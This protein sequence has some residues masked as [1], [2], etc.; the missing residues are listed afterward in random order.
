MPWMGCL[1]K[2]LNFAPT[3][4]R[5]PYENV[6]CGV[7]EAI[8]R[9][10]IPARDAETLRQ[11]VAVTLRKSQLPQRNITAEE[12]RAIKDLRADTDILVL[13]AD[14]GNATVVLDV[15]EYDRKVK[16]LLEDSST[17]KLVSYN[18]NPRVKRKTSALILE[19]SDA[20]PEDAQKQLLRPRSA[21]CHQE[22]KNLAKKLL[23]H[24]L[25]LN[26]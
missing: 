1:N 13:K 11:D 19:C 8:S 2:G 14:K 10:K 15:D 3:P 25:L 18:P 20:I 5:I 22:E 23:W 26:C 9:N 12:L 17:Y 21:T 16:S 4:T 7:E 24:N 6:I